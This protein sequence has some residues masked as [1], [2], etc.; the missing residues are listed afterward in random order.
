MLCCNTGVSRGITEENDGEHDRER[1]THK[2]RRKRD[3]HGPPPPPG[4][5]HPAHDGTS[6]RDELPIEPPSVVGRVIAVVVVVAADF[7]PSG[8]VNAAVAR[9][10]V[11]RIAGAGEQREEVA[12]AAHVARRE[13][14]E[15]A[16]AKRFGVGRRT[17]ARVGALLEGEERGG[18]RR[19]V[20]ALAP[21]G[22]SR[23]VGGGCSTEAAS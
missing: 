3:E 7:V 15:A 16:V 13:R 11:L 5:D 18:H 1:S 21:G 8:E 19:I 22:A 14:A 6:G 12:D 17:G 2:Q 4:A 9:A 10:V 20:V 23:S